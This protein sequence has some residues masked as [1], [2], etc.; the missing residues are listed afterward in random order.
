MSSFHGLENVSPGLSIMYQQGSVGK[1]PAPVLHQQIDIDRCRTSVF[2]SE[3]W[4][5]IA[6]PA[7]QMTFTGYS[8]FLPHENPVLHICALLWLE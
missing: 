8:H 5:F 6:S 1:R 3:N 7:A 4:Q 2:L